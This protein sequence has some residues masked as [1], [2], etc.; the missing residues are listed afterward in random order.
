MLTCD[1]EAVKRR[2]IGR[3]AARVHVEFRTDAPDEFRRAAF[4]GK[5]SGQK[6]KIAR[7]HCFRIGAERLRRRPAPN[8]PDARA[9]PLVQ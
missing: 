5:H 4:R 9:R 8:A 7:L 3:L 6:K 1:S 2:E